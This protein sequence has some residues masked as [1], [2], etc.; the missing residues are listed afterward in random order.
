[1]GVRV[2]QKSKSISDHFP[3]LVWFGSMIYKSCPQK[4]DNF[5][6]KCPFSS[7]KKWHFEH[8]NLRTDSKNLAKHPSKWWGRHLVHAFPFL[9]EYQ[10]NF[11]KSH[12]LEPFSPLKGQNE[13]VVEI[14]QFFGTVLRYHRRKTYQK[15]KVVWNTFV[16]LVH[17]S[18]G[19]S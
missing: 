14:V 19:G 18:L 9:G 5:D 17:P 8:P 4:L 10:A 16:F 12:I 2:Y 7:A 3:L 15:R 6:Q 13:K 11:E 1:M